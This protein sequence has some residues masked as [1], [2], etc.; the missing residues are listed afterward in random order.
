MAQPN[1]SRNTSSALGELHLPNGTD[2]RMLKLRIEAF[3]VQYLI[4]GAETSAVDH[5]IVT[6]HMLS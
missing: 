5:N 1:A 3:I 2:N 4:S 6:L